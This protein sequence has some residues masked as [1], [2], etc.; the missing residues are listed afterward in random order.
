MNLFIPYRLFLST[1]IALILGVCP[2]WGQTSIGSEAE[3]PR[4]EKI[5]F[6]PHPEYTRLLIDLSQPAKYE[7][8]AD[9]AK[10]R[11]VFTFATATL[12]PALKSRAYNDKNLEQISVQTVEGKAR[13][14]FR[15]KNSGTRFFH[16]L[17]PKEPQIIVDLNGQPQSITPKPKIAKAASKK[18][19]APRKSPAPKPKAAQVKKSPIQIVGLRPAAIKKMASSSKAEKIKHGWADYNNALKEYQ[20]KNYPESVKLFEAFAQNYPRSKYLPEI[21]FLTAEAKY[22]I[23]SGESPPAYEP[24]LDAYKFAARKYPLSKFA[25]HARYKI[26][27]IYDRSGLTL[28]AK[29]L[30]EEELRKSSNGPYSDTIKINLAVMVMEDGNYEGAYKAFQRVLKDSP[31][32]IE[33]RG[34]LFTIAKHYFDRN[35]Y[36]RA[37]KI[38]EDGAR[39]WPGEL[40]DRPEINFFMG[41][42]YHSQE[43]YSKARNHLFQLVNLAPKDERSN[44]ALNM[45]GDSYLIEGNYTNALSVFNESARRAPDEHEGQYGK[46]RMADI[47]I[48]SPNIKVRDMLI[49]TSPYLEPFK[50]YNELAEKPDNIETLAEIILSRGNAFSRQQNYLQAI[51]EFK[52][53]LPLGAQSP[54]H[55]KAQI[56]IQKSLVLLVDQYSTQGG[57]LP[58]LYS[59]SDY[60][61]L[62]LGSIQNSKTLVQVGES[63]QS[64]GMFP[65]ALKFYEQAKLKDKKGIL[66]DRIFLNLGEIHLERKNY[67]EVEQVAQT[68]LKMFPKSSRGSDALLLL[69]NAYRG[70]GKYKKA[71][72]V[73]K[74]ALS[75]TRGDRSNIHYLMAQIHHSLRQENAAIREYQKTLNSFD[76]NARVI[77]EYIRTA[78]YKL[79]LTFFHTKKYASAVKALNRARKV[80]PEHTLRPWA[81]FLMAESYEKL[82]NASELTLELKSLAGQKDIDDLLKQA[83]N[84]KLKVLDWEKEFNAQ[85]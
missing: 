59:Y 79:G 42:I 14:T 54:Y 11:V 16:F 52:K 19:L 43:K 72:G 18:K 81:D 46:I 61:S 85:L 30:Y 3:K 65:E 83:V 62:S 47:G 77:P 10:K 40:T 6:G 35:N 23:A 63:Y 39:R 7:V 38:F 45:I 9:L 4:I 26:A 41:K 76:E 27:H 74:K 57:A 28:E 71:L 58:I 29:T 51:D 53:L 84:Y 82:N 33:A 75:R 66:R 70:Q 78:Y 12:N 37:I 22:Q 68:F 67:L 49:D 73:Y 69:A 8:T 5:R 2:A 48:R 60:M 34:A 36:S 25:A 24:A 31:K 17:N 20:A 50:T 64:I 15:F 13:I 80:F 21:F 56:M 55:Q 44:K 32:N 1:L